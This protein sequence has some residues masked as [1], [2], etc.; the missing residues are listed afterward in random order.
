MRS[1]QAI[2]V[3]L[4]ALSAVS[5][6]QLYAQKDYDPAGYSISAIKTPDGVLFAVTGLDVEP[7]GTV[8]VAT[9]LGEVWRLEKGR[10]WTRFAAGLHEPAGLL[11]EDDGSIVVAQKPELTRLVD[12]DGDGQADEY[13]HVASGFEFHDNYHEYHFGPVKD[14]HGYY[15]GTLNLDHNAP[16]NLSLGAMGSLGGFRGGPTG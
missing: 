15:H 5:F 4:A 9:R 1:L 6:F 8:W 13:R 11:I 3:I 14:A 10:D 2:L 16:G 12:L 7:D